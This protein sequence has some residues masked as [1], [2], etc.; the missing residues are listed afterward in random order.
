M[1][2]CPLQCQFIS[3]GQ[4]IP[5]LANTHSLQVSKGAENF[6]Q[7]KEG[8][9]IQNIFGYYVWVNAIFNILAMSES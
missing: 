2:S 1:F 3:L 5:T 9:Y 7:V 6:N 8:W 4:Y